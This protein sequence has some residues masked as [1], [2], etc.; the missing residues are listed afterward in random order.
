MNAKSKLFLMGAVIAVGL[1]AG[2]SGGE[3]SPTG[4]S[5]PTAQAPD[6]AAA[7]Q[8][9]QEQE[10]RR[11]ELMEALIPQVRHFKG[12]PDAPVTIVEFSD[13]L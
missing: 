8:A 2:C 11:Q 7:A 9:A 4:A 13:F 1:L 6:P 3:Q 10:Q 5:L 12:D